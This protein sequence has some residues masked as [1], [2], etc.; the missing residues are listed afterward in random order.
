MSKQFKIFVGSIIF[1]A[2]CSI[3]VSWMHIDECNKL[4]R[5]NDGL[6]EIVTAAAGGRW[7]CKCKNGAAFWPKDKKLGHYLN[8]LDK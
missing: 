7:V 8:G 4:C 3:P 2:G 6:Y 1:L 5:N